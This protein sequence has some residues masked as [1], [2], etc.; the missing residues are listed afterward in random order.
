MKVLNYNQFSN[1]SESDGEKSYTFDELSPEAKKNAIE[2]NRDYDIESYD[3]WEPIIEG[4]TEDL[5]E[6]GMTD[7]DCQF[8][9][10]Y[11]QGDG[12]S[13][14]GKVSDNQKFL[15][16]V[17]V[18]SELVGLGSKFSSKFE[19]VLNEISD[20]LY[21]TIHRESNRHY[22]SKTISASV[23][24]DGEDEIEFDLGLGMIIE[25]DL[26]N[27]CEKIEPKITDWAQKKSDELYSKL[28]N[29]YE[30]LMSDENIES[31][32]KSGGH[33]FDE[34]GNMI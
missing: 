29:H 7:V 34:E 2:K 18:T 6:I 9:G 13:F 10:F 4:F 12:A 24:V 31:N 16:A 19:N 15:K 11:S 17:G 33:E 30:E 32:L 14:T 22:H 1:L 23:E 20:N 25:I 26:N 8:S 5:E 21:I 28:E 27:V 3:W